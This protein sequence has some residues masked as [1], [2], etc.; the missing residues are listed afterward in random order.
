VGIKRFF[1]TLILLAGTAL[2]ALAWWTWDS[3]RRPSSRQ[4]AAIYID[5]PRG[6][7]LERTFQLLTE[8]GV[9]E[10]SLPLRIYIKIRKLHPLIRAGSYYF[11]QAMTPV[12]VL[13]VLRSGGCTLV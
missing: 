3:L 10:N 6:A 1:F 13:E 2:V 11:V 4:H 9:L 12:D 7:T 5:V 8:K